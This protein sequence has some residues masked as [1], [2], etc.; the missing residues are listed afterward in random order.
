[1]KY[2]EIDKSGVFAGIYKRL[3][4]LQQSDVD[5]R[6]TVVIF[7]YHTSTITCCVPDCGGCQNL[8]VKMLQIIGLLAISWLIAWLFKRNN[9][10]V[11]G[12]APNKE[13]LK[14]IFILFTVTAV[15][16]STTYLMKTY[17]AKE[18]YT[19]NP[20]LTANI[21][22][23]GIW[24]TLRGVLTEEL[25][26]RG[27]LLY[28]LIKKIGAK[29]AI[30]ITSVVFGLLHWINNGLWGNLIQMSI[31]FAFTF[32]MGILL[33][34]SYART[35]SMLIPTAIHFGWNLTQNFIFPDRPE[36]DHIFIL[37]GPPPIVTVSYFI[38]F[39]LLL[40]PKVSA[41]GLDYLI[42]K[43]QKQEDMPR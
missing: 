2:F 15:C 6:L 11:L 30:V 34:Y 41:L 27:V 16:C 40:F 4:W 39:F 25:I 38:F 24:E 29:W 12:L 19:I 32:G 7:K 26:C 5:K 36:G 22:F 10:S 14:L 9:L 33:A 31:I 18:Q 1:M 43:K 17:F 21:I 37:A 3:Y 13:R 28:I 23:S 42:I 20:K 8:K 35:F